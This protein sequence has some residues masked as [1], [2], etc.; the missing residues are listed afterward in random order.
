[1]GK[2][3]WRR[4]DVGSVELR[5]AMPGTRAV[6]LVEAESRVEQQKVRELFEALAELADVAP[7][8]EGIIKA[9]VVQLRAGSEGCPPGVLFSKIEAVLKEEF[10]FSLVE[11]SFND[12]IY[13]LVASLCEDSQSEMLHVP[14]CG[15]CNA[16]EPFPTRVTLRNANGQG[17]IEACYCARCSAQQADPS[18]RQFLRSL[19]AADR[20]GFRDLQELD[21]I[22]A[23]AEG[24]DATP[25]STY[26]IAS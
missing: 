24:D 3:R 14:R 8:C 1:M 12:V 7:L 2:L 5:P 19:L 9:Y 20:R 15:I 18:D 23:P 4:E 21:L 16:R 17:V 26:R 25:R 6:F 10:A 11:R 13:H 22:D